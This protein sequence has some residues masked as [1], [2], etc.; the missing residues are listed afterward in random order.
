[1]PLNKKS[2]S[3]TSSKKVL[4]ESNIS[5][6]S[7][8]ENQENRLNCVNNKDNESNNLGNDSQIECRENNVQIEKG[9][10]L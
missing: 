3:Q 2:P 9:N 10:F 1:M 6:N 8:I 4:D 7:S 5:K